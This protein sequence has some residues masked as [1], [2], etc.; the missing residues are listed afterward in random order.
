MTA[1]VNSDTRSHTEQHKLACFPAEGEA[2]PSTGAQ[3]PSCDTW[4]T[5]TRGVWSSLQAV[6]K[7]LRNLCRLWGL[8]DSFSG[9][10]NSARHAV[11]EAGL[12][13]PVLLAHSVLTRLITAAAEH[14]E[15]A[16]CGQ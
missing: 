1:V 16:H 14:P 15:V 12:H 9:W 13:H 7:Q 3:C 8:P 4:L 2:G 6:T 11:R 5:V 10:A